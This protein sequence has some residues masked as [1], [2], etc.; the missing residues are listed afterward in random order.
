MVKLKPVAEDLDL[1]IVGAEYGKGKRSGGLTSYTLAC[2]SGK[3]F[4]EVGKVSSGLKEKEELGTSYKEMDKLLRPL[5]INEIGKGVKVKPKIVLSITYQNL[6]PSS[7]YNSGFAL[8][9]PKITSYRPE[10]GIDDI[11]TLEEIKKEFIRMSRLRKKG[12][13]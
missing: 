13:G 7:N 12:L 4:L 5:I 10:R 8:R 6:Q 2:K 9:F 1:V 11:A 3:D